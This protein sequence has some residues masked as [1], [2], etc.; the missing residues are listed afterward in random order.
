MDQSTLSRKMGIKAG[1]KIVLIG[2][3]EG[4]DGVLAP[5]PG[6]TAVVDELLADVVILF[7]KTKGD[8]DRELLGAISRMR[9]GGAIWIAYL[10]GKSKTPRDLTRDIGWQSTEAAGLEANYL[11]A[12]NEEWS[13]FRFKRTGRQQPTE[14]VLLTQQF[15]GARGAARPIYEQLVREASQLGSDVG[16]AVRKTYV[17]LV[18]GKQFAVLSSRSD[19]GLDIGLKRKGVEHTARFSQADNFGSG[20][21]THKATLAGAGDIDSELLEW[22]RAAYEGAGPQ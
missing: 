20:S 6:D 12:L 8:L 10:K 15:A 4:F 19:G 14:T 5:L 16:L 3:P 1:M 9:E 7:V 2:A 21:I 13:A 11:V 17:A 18:R 22:L